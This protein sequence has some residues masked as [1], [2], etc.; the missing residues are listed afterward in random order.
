MAGRRRAKAKA[1]L[2]RPKVVEKASRARPMVRRG[3]STDR[4]QAVQAG[5]THRGPQVPVVGAALPIARDNATPRGRGPRGE[6]SRKPHNTDHAVHGAFTVSQNI[7]R[8]SIV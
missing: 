6:S 1:S 5:D 3:V 8:K 2:D 7:A 4:L